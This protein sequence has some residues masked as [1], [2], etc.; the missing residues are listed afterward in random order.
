MAEFFN[1]SINQS[2]FLFGF[3]M[4]A[5]MRWYQKFAVED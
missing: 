3:D 1:R 4:T 2:L 5:P